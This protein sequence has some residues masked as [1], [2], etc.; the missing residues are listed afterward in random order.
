MRTTQPARNQKEIAMRILQSAL[1]FTGLI[2]IATP[3]FAGVVLSETEVRNGV[4]GPA[5]FHKTIYVQGKKQ[6]IDT[7]KTETII[8]LDGGHL[9]VVDPGRRSYVQLPFPAARDQDPGAPRLKVNSITLNKT[10]RKRS[11][12]GYPCDEY[13]GVNR[14]S[15]IDVI[16]SQ[17]ISTAAPGAREVAA[18]QHALSSTLAGSKTEKSRDNSAENASGTIALAQKSMIKPRNLTLSDGS[19]PSLLMT[20]TQVKNIRVTELPPST[21]E[22]PAGFHKI[23]TRTGNMIEV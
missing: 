16:I 17:C 14:A 23:V 2:L 3:V 19:R 20:Q 18:F 15:R 10:G 12:E 1:A 6:K 22:P 21:F 4:G 7:G 8:D 5:T 11:I 9:Y 13:K